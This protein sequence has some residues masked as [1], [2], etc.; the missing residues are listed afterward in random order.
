MSRVL[1]LAPVAAALNSTGDTSCDYVSDEVTYVDVDSIDTSGNDV[2]YIG[3]SP[4]PENAQGVFWLKD[5]GGDALVSFGKAEGGDDGMECNNGRL[6]Q[7]PGSNGMFCTTIST[8][9]RG[10]WTFQ[11]EATPWPFGGKFPSA[12]DEFYR[13]CGEKWKFCFDSQDNPQTLDAK[14]IS[15]RGFPCVNVF[16]AS[17]TTGEY[18]GTKDGGH[19]WRITT[20]AL[21]VIPLPSWVPG[22]FDMIQVMDG[23]GA[24]VQPAWDNFAEQNKQIVVYT[25]SPAVVV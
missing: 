1:L 17:T 16:E 6:S 14:P 4:L 20:K 19:Y 21:G 10:G 9:R 3:R 11:A 5:D 24:R 7:D 8:V 12:A 25:G 15:T 23:S 13:T 2:V 18:K 22:N